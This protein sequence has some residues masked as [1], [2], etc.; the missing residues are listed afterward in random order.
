MKSPTDVPLFGSIAEPGF[1]RLADLSDVARIYDGSW[2][3][4]IELDIATT[5]CLKMSIP[6]VQF[7]SLNLLEKA[8]HRHVLIVSGG[9]IPAVERVAINSEARPAEVPAQ[10]HFALDGRGAD[11]G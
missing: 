5:D 7:P 11:A 6:N 8:D 2:V 9:P 10:Q 1:D 4:R 3:G